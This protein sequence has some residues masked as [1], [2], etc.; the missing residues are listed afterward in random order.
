MLLYFKNDSIIQKLIIIKRLHPQGVDKSL[1]QIHPCSLH[2]GFKALQ[3]DLRVTSKRRLFSGAQGHR[4]QGCE[5]G[6]RNINSQVAVC[7]PL[8]TASLLKIFIFIYLAVPGLSSKDPQK[9]TGS[10]VM[11]CELLVSACGIQFPHQG[12]N[13]GPLHWQYGVLAKGP[14][15]NSLCTAS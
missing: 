15:E 8:C 1:K 5:T 12:L 6:C 2:R 7:M 14:P 10:L 11:A 13:P 9:H 4:P 3:A